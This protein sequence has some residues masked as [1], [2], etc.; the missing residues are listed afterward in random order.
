MTAS[1]GVAHPRWPVIG[2]EVAN[3]WGDAYNIWGILVDY[4]I[5]R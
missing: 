3:D 5:L 4:D 2:G 1:G